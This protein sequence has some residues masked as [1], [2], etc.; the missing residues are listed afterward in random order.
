MLSQWYN[1]NAVPPGNADQES[2]PS[3]AQPTEFSEGYSIILPSG[4]QQDSRREYENGNIVYRFRGEERCQMT[5]AVISDEALHRF[6][7]PPQK[8]SDALVKSVPELSE[9]IDGDILAERVSADGMPATF[10]RFF[11]KETYRGVVFTY[12][13]VA[14]DRGTKL[15]LKIAGKYGGYDE[16]E[17]NIVM[18]DHWYDSML[19]LRHIR[20]L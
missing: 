7:A 3:E 2:D 6:S 9:G 20:G 17:K 16:N 5:F 15:V 4:F 11:E 12:Y 8:Y 18:P 13:M 19:T 14:M 10:F 1:V